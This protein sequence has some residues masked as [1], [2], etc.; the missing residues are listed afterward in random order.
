MNKIALAALALSLG[1]CMTLDEHPVSRHEHD[2]PKIVRRPAPVAPVKPEDPNARADY[3]G[4]TNGDYSTA[5]RICAARGEFNPDGPSTYCRNHEADRL[6]DERR[7]RE[8]P[9]KPPCEGIS[10][11]DVRDVQ[12]QFPLMWGGARGKP[13]A[14]ARPYPWGLNG[15]PACAV[16][17]LLTFDGEIAYR[18]RYM[19]ERRPDRLYL[20]PGAL[21]SLPIR[22]YH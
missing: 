11:D 7:A 19:V 5:E 16:E 12:T 22:I 9:R 4:H 20:S 8:P 2:P 1:G 10:A 13:L 3:A 18:F 15:E 14:V 6:R 21:L 17:M